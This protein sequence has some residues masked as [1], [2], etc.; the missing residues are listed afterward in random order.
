MKNNI[1]TFTDGASKGNPGPG[2]WGAVIVNG[3]DVTELGGREENTT[4]NRMELRAI[5]ESLRKVSTSEEEKIIYTD[6]KYALNGITKWITNWKQNGW[7]TK[8]KQEVLNRDLWEEIDRLIESQKIVWELIAGHAGV[9]GNERADVIASSF[10]ENK[11]PELFS[12][13][14]KDYEVDVLNIDLDK[15]T[16][17][18]KARSKMKAY[19]YLSLVNGKLEKHRTWAECEKRIN[20]LNNVKFRKAISP[21]DEYKIIEE[22]GI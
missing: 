21:E 19:S 15:A 18:K 20:G 6:S 4:N 16:Q 2:G 22:W 3:D 12:G 5:L 10:G 1:Q 11:T 13:K 7:Q 17:E 9:L 14:L 8:A